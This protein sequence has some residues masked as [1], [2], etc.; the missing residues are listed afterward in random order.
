MS[1][2]VARGQSRKL[3]RVNTYEVIATPSVD[4]YVT[5]QRSS[6]LILTTKSK[7]NTQ[8]ITEK[9]F[10]SKHESLKEPLGVKL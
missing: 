2:L 6:Q 1:L 7:L 5:N 3:Y 10:V 8:A 9:A 4:M